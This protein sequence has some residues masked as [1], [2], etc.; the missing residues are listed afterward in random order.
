MKALLIM[1]VVVILYATILEPEL[2]STEIVKYNRIIGS[3]ILL[4][5]LIV[6]II[7]IKKK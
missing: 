5:D 4:T 1:A 6:I 7:A 3:Y 2:S